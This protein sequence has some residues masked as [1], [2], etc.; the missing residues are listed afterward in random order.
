MSH[1]NEKNGWLEYGFVWVAVLAIKNDKNVHSMLKV[2]VVLT[3]RF[4]VHIY[5]INNDH[6]PYGNITY[7][8]A[9]VW[10]AHSHALKV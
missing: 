6:T 10:P 7:I 1:N 3:L 2:Y 8:H 9:E 5:K 4:L